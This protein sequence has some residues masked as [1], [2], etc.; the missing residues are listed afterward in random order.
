M[1]GPPDHME[2]PQDHMGGP[3]EHTAGP[4]EPLLSGCRTIQTVM[5]FILRTTLTSIL[6]TI[7]V[8]IIEITAGQSHMNLTHCCALE[9]I[10]K[11]DLL[12]HSFKNS[13]WNKLQNPTLKK[14]GLFHIV[15]TPA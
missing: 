7:N 2:G 1:I 4:P 12:C 5:T 8:A 3:Q 13:A 11:D 9:N 10:T 14:L 15:I 6:D